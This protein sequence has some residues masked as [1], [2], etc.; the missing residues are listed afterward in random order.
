MSQATKLLSVK[1]LSKC[2]DTKTLEAQIALR[3]HL[4]RNVLTGQLYPAILQN[5]CSKINER[6][7]GLRLKRAAEKG[8]IILEAGRQ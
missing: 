2:D 8:C 1:E 6:L 7:H 3:L 4:I 5:E